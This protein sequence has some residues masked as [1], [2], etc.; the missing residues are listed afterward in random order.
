MSPNKKLY[1]PE[2]SLEL[3]RI[4]KGDLASAKELASVSREGR[5]ENV[6][7]LAQQSVEKTLKAVLNHLRIAFPLVHELGTLVALFPDENLPPGDFDLSA[8]NPYASSMRYEE[9]NSI[10]SKEE[11]DSAIKAAD[12]VLVWA[13]KFFE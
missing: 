9:P 8:L 11:V 1:K 5:L 3:F 13:E 7:Y 10:L 4:A 6:V 12:S 2:Y